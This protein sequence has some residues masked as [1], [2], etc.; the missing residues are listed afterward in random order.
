M[1]VRRI[2]EHNKKQ[3]KTHYPWYNENV[4]SYFIKMENNIA[5]GWTPNYGPLKISSVK[6]WTRANEAIIKGGFPQTD[7]NGRLGDEP[8]WYYENP[9]KPWKIRNCWI[10]CG[11]S[12]I[13]RSLMNDLD[14]LEIVDI[15]WLNANIVIKSIFNPT[16]QLF[17][18][19]T[20]FSVSRGRSYT[21]FEQMILPF[22]LQTW[23]VIILTCLMTFLTV[24][25]ISMAKISY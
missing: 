23:I 11:H 15:K 8:F 22:D 20:T 7:Y 16:S 10:L 13:Q 4:L 17:Y 5:E 19:H 2:E 1:W 21:S 14:I 3:N 6:F 12:D 25:I 24:F 18:S 9:K